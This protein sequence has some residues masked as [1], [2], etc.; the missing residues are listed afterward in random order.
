MSGVSQAASHRS[1]VEELSDLFLHNNAAERNVSASAA[2][3]ECDHVRFISEV[4]ECEA[5][6][7][8]VPSSHNFVSYHQD[9]VLVAQSSNA[10]VPFNWS[11]QNAVGTYNGF[12]PDS[13]D[14]FRSLVQDLFFQQFEVEISNIIFIFE[15]ASLRCSVSVR[16]IVLNE[17]RTAWFVE[18]VSRFT[19]QHTSASG[20]TVVASVLGED[21]Q[22]ASVLSCDLDSVFVRF[23]TS[24]CEEYFTAF[25]ASSFNNSF[26][27]ISSAVHSESR[28]HERDLLSLFYDGIDD[29]LVAVSQVGVNQLR[30]HVCVLLAV[31]VPEV[32]TFSLSYNDRIHFV[33]SRPGM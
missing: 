10:L 29:S 4:H 16:S 15:L 30:R 21:L 11:D 20:R 31:F 23:S 9:V 22:F 3:S 18:E 13:C 6:T 24:V 27:S 17:S 28:S 8:S 12:E 32:Q 19:S 25:E 33:L 2:L 1:F 5:L 7:S 26:S 14:L